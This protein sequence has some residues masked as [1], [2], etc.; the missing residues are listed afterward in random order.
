MKI[1]QRKNL[2]HF[3]WITLLAINALAF[4]HAYKFTH[5][6]G[7]EPQTKKPT[8]LSTAEKMQTLFLGVNNPRPENNTLPL[9]KFKTLKIQSNKMIE[10][11]HIKTD[12]S[13]GT[14]VIFHGYKGKKAA[15][16]DK[17]DAFVA[18]GYNTLVVDFMGSGGSEGNQCTLGV[19]EAEQVKSCVDYLRKIGEKNIILFG[20]SM[21]AVSILSAIDKC[22]VQ[23]EA[24]IL[25]CPFGT[26]YKTT[27]ARFRNMGV[28][29]FPMAG[30][31][32]FWGGVQ[33]GFWGFSHQP[34]EYAKSVKCKM[35]LMYGEEDK[36]V[37]RAE[38]DEIFA[39]AKG[40]K[41]LKTF[42]LAGHENYLTKY[43]NEWTKEVLDFLSLKK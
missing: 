25:E 38:T 37:S 8:E 17:S 16:L 6:S 7:T 24:I 4:V 32:V 1:F 12:S 13:K 14:V 40:E 9:H 23:P 29:A 33:N 28:P 30:L 2:K 21:G 34:T 27:A 35:L 22:G 3:L 10:C 43:R 39:N 19:K 20:T 5:F 41:R 26:M 18:M 42:P 15:M 11:W 36:T 31:L